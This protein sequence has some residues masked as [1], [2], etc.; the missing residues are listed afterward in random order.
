MKNAATT[1]KNSST[2]SKLFQSLAGVDVP[3]LLIV[4]ALLTFG[5]VMVLSS[6]YIFAEERSGDGFAF[7]K[8]QF[9]Y[10][11]MGLAGMW[12]AARVPH[13]NWLK[14]GY[15]VLGVA[16]LLL[17][18]VLIPG[19][20]A[21]VG[22][23]QR[24]IR[25]GPIGFQPGE[26]AKFAMIFFVIRQLETKKDRLDRFGPGILAPL[27]VP[28]PGLALLLLQPDFGSTALIVT[29]SMVL[30]FLAGV[31]K[32]YLFTMVAFA[33]M[34]GAALL[35]GSDYRRARLMTFLDPWSDPGGK[36]FQIIQ[37]YLGLF[38]GGWFGV[39][40]GNGKEKLFYLPE[41]HNDF[42]GAVI[43]EE[44]GLIGIGAVVLAYS[45]LVYRGLR[46]AYRCWT[47]SHDSYGM[48]LASGI[49]LILGLQ[50]FINLSVVLGLVPTKGLTLPLISY[51]GSALMVDLFAAGILLSVSRSTDLHST[52]K[53]SKGNG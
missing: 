2:S 21:R 28:L 8:K 14:W 7:I 23:A 33:G 27:L 12:V 32:R 29:I 36:G 34:A 4:I 26:L 47:Q 3:L 45:F 46:I 16:I 25:L 17:A 13:R 18:C 39:G 51:G 22:G 5:L 11:M 48:L 53:L 43:G 10:S 24:W 1:S 19:I 49:T 38:H 6:S 35:L 30:M 31:P 41:A 15:P 42:I 9:A 20:G 40:L 37:S 44:L 50:G 52:G